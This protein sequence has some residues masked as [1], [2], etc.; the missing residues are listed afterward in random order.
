MP[1][2]Y[3]WTEDRFYCKFSGIV[4]LQDVY[5]ATGI[6]YG[7]IRLDSLSEVLIDFSRESQ[8]IVSGKNM[9]EIAYLD[10][11]ASKYNKNLNF[12]F[13]A[14]HPIARNIAESYIAYSKEVGISW[15]YEIFDN[16]DSAL[17]WL[18]HSKKIKKQSVQGR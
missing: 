2:S 7:N 4:D 5:V 9:R 10:K 15:N 6:L 11:A 12:A 18:E 1:F 3:S 14:I 16:S 8:I 13:I 17:Q